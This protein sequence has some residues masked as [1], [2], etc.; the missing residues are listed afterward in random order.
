[1]HK[2]KD[3]IGKPLSPYAVTK[4]ELCAHLLGKYYDFETIGMRHFNVFGPRQHP[5]G[6]YAN[7]TKK[8]AGSL[9][10]GNWFGTTVTTIRH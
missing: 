7:V 4:Y 5:N 8:W 2:M 10:Q 3:T 9:F 6:T 1:M